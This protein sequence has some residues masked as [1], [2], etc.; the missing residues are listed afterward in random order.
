[1]I[2]GSLEGTEARRSRGLATFSRAS[3]VVLP[4]A[5]VV[6]VFTVGPI[7][8]VVLAVP[9][10]VPITSVVSVTSVVLVAGTMVVPVTLVV[11]V[12]RSV[13]VLVELLLELPKHGG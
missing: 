5:S 9:V 11:S 2:A 13:V 7:A 10:T 1:L 6:V 3:T 8:I 12:T 4:I